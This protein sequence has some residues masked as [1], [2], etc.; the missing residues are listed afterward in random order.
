MRY[1]KQF[2]IILIVSFSGEMLNRLI[3]LPIPASIYGLVFM[4]AALRMKIVKVS[5]IKETSAFMLDIMP[6]TFI[7][8]AVGLMTFWP[9]IRANLAA[10]AVIMVAS[11]VI[12]FF[13]SGRV[14][15]RLMDREAK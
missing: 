8:S 3:P 5:D 1:V 13:V 2:L 9:T 14:T 7:P 11:T 15:Q 10:F 6:L 4:L 12:V